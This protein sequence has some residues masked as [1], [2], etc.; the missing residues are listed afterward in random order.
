MK[1]SD[2]INKR[3]EAAKKAAPKRPKDYFKKIGSKGGKNSTHRPMRD[4]EYAR[5]LAFLSA[6][7]RRQNKIEREKLQQEDAA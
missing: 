3:S 2:E 4:P 7:K 6:E 1:P 5:K